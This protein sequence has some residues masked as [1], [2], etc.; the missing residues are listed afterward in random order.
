M[1]SQLSVL[2]TVIRAAASARRSAK[3]PRADPHHDQRGKNG[4]QLTPSSTASSSS[5]GP[6]Y[7]R[8]HWP[9]CSKTKFLLP[10]HRRVS[11]VSRS[12][13]DKLSSHRRSPWQVIGSASRGQ[14]RKKTRSSARIRRRS[15]GSG[16]QQSDLGLVAGKGYRLPR[17]LA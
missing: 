4:P 12:D 5:T 17:L 7:L 10:G 15:R 3:T 16:L 9:R 1:R 8:R 13:E 6:L 14:C 2:L 11:S